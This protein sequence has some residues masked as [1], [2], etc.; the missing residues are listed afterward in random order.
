MRSKIFRVVRFVSLNLSNSMIASENYY[1]PY[2][3]VPRSL[4]VIEI[5]ANDKDHLPKQTSYEPDRFP[6]WGVVVILIVAFHDR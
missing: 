3:P 2:V 4:G 1:L 5:F 6:G